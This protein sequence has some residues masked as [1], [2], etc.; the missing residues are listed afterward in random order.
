MI[1]EEVNDAGESVALKPKELRI[2]Q[3]MAGVE[4]RLFYG[5]LSTESDFFFI[6]VARVKDLA[7]DLIE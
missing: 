3:V 6:D 5:S 1:V 4:N 2:A 7:V